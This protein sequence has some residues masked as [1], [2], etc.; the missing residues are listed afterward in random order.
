MHLKVICSVCE[1]N[2]EFNSTIGI[3]YCPK[4]GYE[5]KLEEPNE[6]I[7]ELVSNLE[8]LEILV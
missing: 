1:K 3:Y 4:H 8:Q 2:A 7:E 5:T 6:Y